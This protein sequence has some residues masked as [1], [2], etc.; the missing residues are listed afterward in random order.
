MVDGHFCV[1]V[2]PSVP[3]AGEP[4]IA[5]CNFFTFYEEGCDHITIQA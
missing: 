4:S 1:L 5:K 2:S 3:S